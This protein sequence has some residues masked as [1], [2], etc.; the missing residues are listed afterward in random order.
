[1]RQRLKLKGYGDDVINS[2]VDGLKRS[3]G[4]DDEK[5]ARFWMQSRMH[6]NPVG[7]TV[8][9]RELKLK[10]ISDFVIDATLEEKAAG[11]DEY[12]IA[13]AMAE[14]RYGR[15]KKLD[16]RKAMKRLYDFLVRRGFKFDTVQRI[17][18]ELIQN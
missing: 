4:L 11:F 13:F 9:R 2:V 1:M 14:E 17:V 18:D 7:D 12:K 6:L 8:F 5:F 16:R 15:L 10:G 3:G